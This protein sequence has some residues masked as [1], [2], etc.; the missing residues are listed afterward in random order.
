MGGGG[1]FPP[2]DCDRPAVRA[3]IGWSLLTQVGVE[4]GQSQALLQN[5]AP[6]GEENVHQPA[7]VVQRLHPPLHLDTGCGHTERTCHK[8]SNMSQTPLHLDTDC[9]H[10]RPVTNTVT[11]HKHCSTW[12]QTVDTHRGRVTNTVTCHKHHS[13]WTQAVDT[14]RGRVTNIVTRHKHCSTW[15]QA[16]DTDGQSQTQ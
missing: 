15:T 2:P 4:H 5:V 14:D 1:E 9:G 8:H 7:P 13:T 16:V 3:V 6:V 11:R 10:R 12:T